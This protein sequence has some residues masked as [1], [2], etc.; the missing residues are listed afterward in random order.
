MTKLKDVT[1]LCGVD[2]LPTQVGT[3]SA[4]QKKALNVFH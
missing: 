1:R 2:L 3:P 4:E